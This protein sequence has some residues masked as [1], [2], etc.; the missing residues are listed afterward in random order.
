MDTLELMAGAMGN[1]VEANHWTDLIDQARS[2]D[3][4][5]MDLLLVQLRNYLLFVVNAELSDALQSKFGG[6]DVV[7]QSML[8]A[9]QSIDQFR[10]ASKLELMAWMKKI[11][12]NNL[13]DESRRYHGTKRRDPSREVS[14]GSMHQKISGPGDNKLSSLDQRSEADEELVSALRKLPDRQREV[15]EARHRQG[16]SYRQIAKQMQVSENAVRKLWSRGIQNLK[17][18]VGEL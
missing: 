7:Q 4:H 14:L 11:A 3:D 5:A 8:E 12:I 9:Y 17:C 18:S 15:I 6:S 2:G 13:Q 1:A 16:Q 10:G